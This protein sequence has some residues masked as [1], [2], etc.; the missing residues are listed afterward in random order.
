MYEIIDILVNYHK[1][2][3]TWLIGA[4]GVVDGEDPTHLGDTEEASDKEEALRAADMLVAMH[5]SKSP[6]IVILVN[7]N[8]HK[9]LEQYFLN[10]YKC[11]CG[12]EWDMEDDCTC[13]DRCPECRTSMS[14]YESEDI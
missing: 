11:E 12:H 13:D 9:V 10:H 3:D 1:E 14:P 2:P 5:K 6:R 8:E 4:Y 7:G